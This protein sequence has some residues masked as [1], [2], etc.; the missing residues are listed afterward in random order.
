MSKTSCAAGRLQVDITPPREYRFLLKRG[1]SIRNLHAAVGASGRFGMVVL[2]AMAATAPLFAAAPDDGLPRAPGPYSEANAAD[3]RAQR[4]ALG[5]PRALQGPALAHRSD[6]RHLEASAAARRCAAHDRHSAPA[7][8]YGRRPIL[9]GLD[10][11][12]NQGRRGGA[13]HARANRSGEAHGREVSGRFRDR[14]YGRRR[15]QNPQGRQDR[16][17]DRHRG[18]PSDQQLARGAAADVRPR[19]A[20]HDVD[21]RA[22]IRAG[23]MPPP[24]RRCTTA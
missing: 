3:R 19:R 2:L 6:I 23:P 15:A 11:G 14:L 12:R 13:D 16:L 8:R 4:S 17:A 21:P 20:L 7:R 1:R 18:R 24:T 10:S 22:S 9:V 5:D